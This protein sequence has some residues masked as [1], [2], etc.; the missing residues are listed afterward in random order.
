ML[1][2]MDVTIKMASLAPIHSLSMDEPIKM[3][4]LASIHSLSIG[5]FLA[6]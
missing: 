6:G 5:F 3:A 2:E 1:Q 4:F